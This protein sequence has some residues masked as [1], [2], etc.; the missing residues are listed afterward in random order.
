VIEEIQKEI[1]ERV[2][3]LVV[4]HIANLLTDSDDESCNIYCNY[5]YSHN[6]YVKG[7]ILLHHHKKRCRDYEHRDEYWNEYWNVYRNV[8]RN[9]HNLRIRRNKLKNQLIFSGDLKEA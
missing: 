4:E 9:V 5:V 7:K 2:S 3:R 1:D 6:Q 8:Y